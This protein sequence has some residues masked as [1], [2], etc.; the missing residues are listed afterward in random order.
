MVSPSRAQAAWAP[1][2]EESI[3][4]PGLRRPLHWLEVRARHML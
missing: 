4:S 2:K 3:S 1:W